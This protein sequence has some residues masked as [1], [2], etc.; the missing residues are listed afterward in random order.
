MFHTHSHCAGSTALIWVSEVG[1]SVFSPSVWY[2]AKVS[3]ALQH[4]QSCPDSSTS[5]P[6]ASDLR[7]RLGMGMGWKYQDP[8]THGAG[9]GA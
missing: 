5:H 6:L 1:P 4:W 7:Q 2:S 8:S 3:R 9:W